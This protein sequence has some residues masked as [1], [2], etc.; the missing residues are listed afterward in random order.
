MCVLLYKTS[1]SVLEVFSKQNEKTLKNK[2]DYQEWCVF[3]GSV[4][5]EKENITKAVAEESSQY[6]FNSH[7]INN[8]WYVF[9]KLK[10]TLIFFLI[11]ECFFLKK[12]FLFSI[13]V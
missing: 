13:V 5:P 4:V 3:S 2:I 11:R 6:S 1:H 8:L 9:P 10:D 7:T 12:A